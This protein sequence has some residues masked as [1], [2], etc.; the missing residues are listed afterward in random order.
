M[1]NGIGRGTTPV[2]TFEVDVDLRN[3]E[4]VYL[5]Y[6]QG[7]KTILEK[8]KEELTI[9]ENEVSIRLTQEETLAFKTTQNVEIQFRARFPDEDAIKSNIIN[10]TAER[11]LKEGVI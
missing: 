4:V 8:T 5:T 1:A 10:T 2:N 7:N 6:K 9:T 3:A 11:I